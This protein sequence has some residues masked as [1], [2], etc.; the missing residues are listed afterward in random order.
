[1]SRPI[2]LFTGQWADM[3]LEELAQKASGW[4]YEGLE[5]ICAGD[6][7]N[8]HQ[9]ATDKQYCEEKLALLAK[10][11]L[12][13]YA[14]NNALAGQQVCDANRD[15]HYDAIAPA[16]CQGDPEKKRAWA[17]ESMKDAAR[18]AKNLGLYIVNGFVGSSIW[19][20]MYRFPPIPEETIQAGFDYFARM[21]NPIFDLFDE[22]GIQFGMEVHPAEIAFDIITAK[23]ALAA[24]GHRETLGFN[25][26]PSH[27][28]WQMVDPVEFIRAFPDRI[29]HVHMKDAAVQL[30]GR[31]SILASHLNFGDPDRGWDFRSLGRGDVDFELIIRALNAIGY[32][33]P[34]C[35]EW[36]DNRMEREQ[37][38]AEACEF[39]RKIDFDPAPVAFDTPFAIE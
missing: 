11:N 29:Y 4:G 14:I 7:L 39:T 3:P 21:W 32:Q 33:G 30:N 35:V 26:D 16:S 38:V 34:L 13:L 15:A 31:T 22:C 24:V 5:L 10:Y 18:A 2:T 36:E 20:L 8:A 17:V 25:F 19:H 12:K 23:R 1:M 28:Q 9:A 6:H 37:G 27:L